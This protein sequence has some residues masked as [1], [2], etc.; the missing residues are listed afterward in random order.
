MY[1]FGVSRGARRRLLAILVLASIPATVG[2]FHCGPGRFDAISGGSRA[3]RLV[4]PV[5][6]SFVFTSNPTL[7]WELGPNVKKGVVEICEDRDCTR[8]ISSQPVQGASAIV[9]IAGG[10][11]DSSG[12]PIEIIEPRFWRV[13]ADGPSGPPSVSWELNISPTRQKDLAWGTLSDFNADGVPEVVVGLPAEQAVGVAPDEY[14]PRFGQGEEECVKQV[15]LRRFRE[16]PDLPGFG[17]RVAIAGDVDGDGFV[18]LI[19]SS[20]APGLS[21][22][23]VLLFHGTAGGGF[24]REGPGELVTTPTATFV[25]G[26][27]SVAGGGDIDGDGYADILVG[28]QDSVYVMW[29]GPNGLDGGRATKVTSEGVDLGCTVIGA[30]DLDGDR[31]A[32]FAVGADCREGSS[33]GRVFVFFGSP[34]RNRLERMELVRPPEV[35]SFGSTLALAGDLDGDGKSDLYV[36]APSSGKAFIFRTKEGRTVE[37]ADTFAGDGRPGFGSAAALD[38]VNGLQVFRLLYVSSRGD[39]ATPGGVSQWPLLPNDSPYQLSEAYPEYA[40]A[41]NGRI[42]DVAY[43]F[44]GPPLVAVFGADERTRAW[45]PSCQPDGGFDAIE[46]F[47]ESTGDITFAR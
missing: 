40:P 46:V 33:A 1:P 34:D 2:V 3:P 12:E 29:G 43:S 17:S 14:L 28:D 30:G 7:R 24:F 16:R 45:R 44:T 4:A 13:R 37:L 10:I 25:F 15:P 6:G 39:V 42:V 8:V 31:F 5:S 11:E 38:V 9:H 19:A 41:L 26:G 32:D 23:Q 47:A 35:A 21:R 20:V 22:A 36:G 18:D 27:R